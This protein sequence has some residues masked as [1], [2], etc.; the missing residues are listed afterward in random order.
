MTASPI[1]V[2]IVDDSPTL[3]AALRALLACEPSIVVVGEAA[4]GGAAVDLARRLQPDVITMDV[5]MPGLDGWAATAAIMA[6]SP[7]R[8]IVLC[9]T[10]RSDHAALTF[11][12]IAAGALEV[13]AKPTGLGGNDLA[14]FGKRLVETIRLMAEVP[15]VGRRRIGHHLAAPTRADATIVG[16]VASTGGPPAIVELLRALPSALGACVVIA[17]H[18]SPGFTTGLAR[19]IAESTSLAVDI[20]GTGSACTPGTV[21][22]AP[23]AHH[24]EVA[25]DGTLR[26]DHDPDGFCPSGDRL[27]VSLA[28]ALG[29][30]AAGVVLSGMGADGTQGLL[31]IRQAGGTTIA[32]E[33]STCVAPGMPEAAI[34]RGAAEWV[35]SLDEIARAIGTI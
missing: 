15:V 12:A 5:L 23:D 33:P 19:W 35:L 26:L 27:L 31:A 7:T 28:T 1:R 6:D 30:R 17:Q 18:I 9:D 34:E 11:R 10:S 22:I 14:T 21:W 2:L 16:I 13:I 32:Q 25:A 4:S 8:I 20:A 29:P 24:V 3:R